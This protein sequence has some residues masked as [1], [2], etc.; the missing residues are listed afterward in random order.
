MACLLDHFLH[1]VESARHIELHHRTA[2]AVHRTAGNLKQLVHARG[3]IDRADL[4]ARCLKQHLIFQL[5]VVFALCRRKRRFT[6][7][8][9][10]IRQVQAVLLLE[11]DGWLQ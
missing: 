5:L 3:G 9:R 10:D 7:H 8:V 4:L 2:V 1:Y 6:L 11:A